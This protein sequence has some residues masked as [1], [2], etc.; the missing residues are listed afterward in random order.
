[1]PLSKSL[2]D[3]SKLVIPGGVNSPVRFY[4]PYP[5][6]ISS[7]KGSK[8]VT[9]DHITL[10]DYCMG[11]G[12]VIMGHA[13]SEIIEPVKAQLEMGNLYCMPTEQELELAQLLSKLVPN[14]ERVRMMN[15]GTEATLH[16][17]RLARAMTQNRRIVKFDGCYHGSYDDVLT[18]AGSGVAE[19][20]SVDGQGETRKSSNE[21]LILQ[22]NDVE[23]V[24]KMVKN[25][26]DIACVI[27]EPV[28]ANMG[29]ITPK[30]EFLSR[31][32]RITAENNIVL[33]FD[34]VVTGFR[35]SLGGASE[36]LGITS[37][38]STFGKAIGNGFPLS[39]VTGR[40]EIMEQ[41]SPSGNV[42][43][44]ST[45]AGNPVS[46]RAGLATVRALER[47]RSVIY[48]RMSRMCDSIVN[49]I[50]DEIDHMSFACCVNHI[51]SMFQIF[52]TDRKVQNAYDVRTSNRRYYRKL[53]DNLMKLRVFVPPSQFETCFL[54]A[55]HTEED[56]DLTIE[57]FVNALTE[58]T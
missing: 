30:Q 15:T 7:A 52:F 14:A 24:E 5:V 48:P 46:V 17:I 40:K 26:N 43:Q 1:M 11:Y 42:Y 36:Y 53:F 4:T 41:F 35:L 29:L 3:S 28:P 56:I 34:E 25:Y 19:L 45:Y 33:I 58:V 21:T 16:A 8:I 32:R 44:G 39:A 10:T 38:L 18:S 9:A 20:P 31:L 50:T 27:V 13:N 37:D 22:F 54:S 47:E 57:A 2:F 12:A 6:F 55:A 51:G 23:S 49:G